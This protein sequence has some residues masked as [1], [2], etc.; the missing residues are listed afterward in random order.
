MFWL[1][2]QFTNHRLDDSNIPILTES[3]V[4]PRASPGILLTEKTTHDP[5]GQCYPEVG[6]EANDEHG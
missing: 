6:G 4:I 3:A 2:D 5:T 1:L